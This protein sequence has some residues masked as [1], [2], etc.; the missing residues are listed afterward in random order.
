[1]QRGRTVALRYVDIGAVFQKRRH[2]LL[3]AA[4]DRICQRSFVTGACDADARGRKH[5]REPK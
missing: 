2:R 3:I 1:M 4:L 5:Q